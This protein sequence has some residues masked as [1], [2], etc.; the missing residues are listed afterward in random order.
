MSQKRKRVAAALITRMAAM[1][2][3]VLDEGATVVVMVFGFLSAA[4]WRRA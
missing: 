2:G 4:L 1:A 3:R